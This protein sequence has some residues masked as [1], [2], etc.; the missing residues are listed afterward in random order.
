MVGT[1]RSL[2]TRWLFLDVCS[3]TSAST[4]RLFDSCRSTLRSRL[5]EPSIGRLC[6]CIISR[7][8]RPGLPT[9]Y[10]LHSTGYQVHVYILRYTSRCID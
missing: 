4:F 2:A 3:L 1:G 10:R 9:S 5:F 8:L 6:M 7:R